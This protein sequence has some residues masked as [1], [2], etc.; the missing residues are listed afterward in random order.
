MIMRMG[1]WG[2]IRH[3]AL[4]LFDIKHD[5]SEDCTALIT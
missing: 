1:M 2:W 5:K 4:F 3:L